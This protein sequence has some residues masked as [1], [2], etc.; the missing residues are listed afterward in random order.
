MAIA[1]GF[2]WAGRQDAIDVLLAMM[3]VDL[4]GIALVE[5][6]GEVLG[7]IDAAMLAA[8]ASESELEVSEA[9]LE[10]ARNVGSQPG[11][12]RGQASG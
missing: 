9:T 8:G 12:R 5:I 7:G 6:G 4:Y 10:I 3:E 1:L 11:D 2:L